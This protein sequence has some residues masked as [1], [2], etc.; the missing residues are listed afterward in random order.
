MYKPNGRN[1]ER[2]AFTMSHKHVQVRGFVYTHRLWPSR[3]VGIPS[4][5]AVSAPTPSP[6]IVG[7]VRTPRAVCVRHLRYV[8]THPRSY[9]IQTLTDDFYG[10]HMPFFI[11]LGV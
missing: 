11:P 8:C 2:T 1:Y 7:G 10:L 4:G 6:S 3:R 9:T 5:R